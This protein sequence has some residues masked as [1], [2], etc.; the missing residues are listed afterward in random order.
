[1]GDAI[2]EAEGSSDMIPALDMADRILAVGSG[3]LC[4]ITFSD[5]KADSQANIESFDESY[6]IQLTSSEDDFF[7]S[8][9]SPIYLFL[10]HPNTKYTVSIPGLD[11]SLDYQTC[12]KYGEVS[13][14][15]LDMMVN[16]TVDITINGNMP[17][18]L[19]VVGSGYRFNAYVQ[20]IK[21]WTAWVKCIGN[22]FIEYCGEDGVW[23][24]D[25]RNSI[26]IDGS[27]TY[28]ITFDTLL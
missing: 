20:G 21:S 26:R 16:A 4:K 19:V 23:V 22:Y 17:S 24:K 9:Q 6:A 7:P 25:R 11:L 15:N 14:F 28:N 2:R 12:G 3:V 27:N 5:D 8:N 13:C 18:Q 10:K 1:M